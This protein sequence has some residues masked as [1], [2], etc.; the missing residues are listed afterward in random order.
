MKKQ[1]NNKQVKKAVKK[2]V[3][4]LT[5]KQLQKAVTEKLVNFGVSKKFLED[6]FIFTKLG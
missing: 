1:E 4:E 2:P 5:E 6:H 3:S